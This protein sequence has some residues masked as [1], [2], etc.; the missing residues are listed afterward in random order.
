[1]VST[2]LPVG[3]ESAASVAVDAVNTALDG[4]LAVDLAGVSRD[5]LLEVA[6]RFEGLRRRLPVFEHALINE[7][8]GRGVAHELCVPSTAALWRGLL[9]ISPGEAKRRV[10]A[11]MNLG[12][13]RGLTGEVLPPLFGAVAAAQAAGLISAE[14]AYVITTAIDALPGAV[15]AD[16]EERVQAALV[17]HATM[18]DP[19]ELAKLARRMHDVLNP[20]GTLADDA[21]HQRRRDFTPAPQPGRVLHPGWAV[22]PRTHRPGRGDARLPRRA[23]AG[24][25]RG[26]RR[27]H[28]GNA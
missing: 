7:V 3:V 22:H 14:H 16:H 15:A 27:P 17:E 10:Q 24:R 28:P 20:D 2:V 1:M 23:P 4:L 11:A 21:D 19:L 9:R 13:R 5:G 8:D 6:R 25:R 26:P 12:P 18:F